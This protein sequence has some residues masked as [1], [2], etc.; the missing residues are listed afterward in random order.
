MPRVLL[1]VA[2]SLSLFSCATSPPPIGEAE[3]AALLE[4]Q[5]RAWNRGDMTAFMSTYWASPKLTFV[6]S[7]GLTRGHA[8]TLARYRAS[9][10]DAAARGELSFELLEVRPIG[11]GGAALVIGRWKLR[12]EEPIEGTFSLVVERRPE[13]VRIVHDHSSAD[14]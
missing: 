9:Y 10:P 3:V 6:G 4:T 11:T 13:G 1:P 5:A 14:E 8:E 7:S 12:R 2:I